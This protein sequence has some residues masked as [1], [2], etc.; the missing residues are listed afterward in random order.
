VRFGPSNFDL[1][2]LQ[3]FIRC[4]EELLPVTASSGT[5]GTAV[6]EGE[7]QIHMFVV[8]AYSSLFLLPKVAAVTWPL[9]AGRAALSAPVS[10]SKWSALRARLSA[11]RITGVSVGVDGPRGHQECIRKVTYPVRRCPVLKALR[12]LAALRRRAAHDP[13]STFSC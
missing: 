1:N 13:H 2:S 3:S 8:S 11:S 4:H 7:E 6:S 9:P 5:L 12:T 10:K